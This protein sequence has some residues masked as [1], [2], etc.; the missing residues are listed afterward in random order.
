MNKREGTGLLDGDRSDVETDDAGVEP[1]L[2]FRNKALSDLQPQPNWRRRVREKRWPVL[3]LLCLVLPVVVVIQHVTTISHPA[4]YFIGDSITEQGSAPGTGGWVT[5][6][7]DQYAQ[8]AVVINRGL[9]GWNTRLVLPSLLASEVKSANICLMRLQMVH[10]ASAAW[11]RSRI[12]VRPS[13]TC[14]DHGLVRSQRRSA[15]RQ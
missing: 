6:M 15:G 5:L 3:L 2:D 10:P 8:S 9:S 12:D 13:L 1:L 4:F 7:Q 11:L 14:L